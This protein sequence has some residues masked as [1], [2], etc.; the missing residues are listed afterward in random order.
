MAKLKH[1]V[2]D[3]DG[4]Q[5]LKGP[6][7]QVSKYIK[8]LEKTISEILKTPNKAQDGAKIIHQIKS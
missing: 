7:E 4:K 8:G 6:K 5:K 3:L 1:V 2:W